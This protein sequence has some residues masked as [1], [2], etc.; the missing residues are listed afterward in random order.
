[1]AGGSGHALDRDARGR[2]HRARHGGGR[3]QIRSHPLGDG[4]RGRPTSVA[5][6]P[7]ARSVSVPISARKR[8]GSR[9]LADPPAHEISSDVAA[10]VIPTYA[11]RLSSSIPSS[12]RAYEIGNSPSDAP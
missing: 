2:A 5:L 9:P 12:V 3:R 10:R 6:A 7:T 11:R 1:G 4:Q 8:D